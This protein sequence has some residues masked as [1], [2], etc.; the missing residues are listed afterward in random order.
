LNASSGQS[1]SGLAA[2][3]TVCY[4]RSFRLSS[5]RRW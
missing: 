4:S 5:S 3:I 2:S 1:R